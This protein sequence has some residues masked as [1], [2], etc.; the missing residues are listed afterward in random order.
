MTRLSLA[1]CACLLAT[2]FAKRPS[3]R[4][5][6]RGQQIGGAA[7][8]RARCAGRARRQG[9]A[10]QGRLRLHRRPGVEAAG[11]DR[12]SSCSPTSPARGL[13]AHAG[14]Q[15]LGLSGQHRLSGARG[16]ALGRHPEQRLRAQ[17]SAV[18]GILHDRS[19]RPHRRSPGPPH[20]RD[21]RGPLADARREGRQAHGARRQLPGPPLRRPQ[22]R[23]GQEQRRHLFHRHL[24]LVPPA[25][26]GP[27]QGARLHR[28]LSCGRT[29]SC[30]C[31]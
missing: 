20:P 7:R 29:A 8:P 28:R 24:R 4:R 31:W 3:R 22:R 21:L 9:R 11:Q 23:R 6:S 18:R 2:G 13:E 25:R 19:G 12:L 30:R 27:A 1:A 16:V 26:E 17:R 5:Q 10:R 14:R 15:G